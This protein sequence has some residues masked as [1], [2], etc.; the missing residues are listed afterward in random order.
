MGY[1]GDILTEATAEFCVALLLAT[2]RRLTESIK[3]NDQQRF[4]IS[5]NE[6]NVE[7]KDLSIDPS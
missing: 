5:T 4:V 7:W 3:F 2:G 6:E 1:A